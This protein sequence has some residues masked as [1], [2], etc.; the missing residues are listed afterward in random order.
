[1]LIKK[2]KSWKT[3]R[4]AALIVLAIL[5]MTVLGGIFSSPEAYSRTIQTLDTQK[6]IATTLSVA[7]TAASTTLSTLPEDT[8]SPIASELA[9][10]SL[11]LF[12][13]VC[14]L[15]LEKFLLTTF[16]WFAFT[17]LI[18]LACVLEI[19]YIIKSDAALRTYIR[20]I[21]ILALAL[22][23]IVPMSARVTEMVY[24]TFEDSVTS[25]FSKADGIVE[26]TMA[27][28]E[29]ERENAFVRFFVDLKDDV[30]SL[31]ETAKNMLGIFTD[32][33]AVL[34]ITSCV[35]P[36]LTA[37]LFVWVLKLVFSINVPVNNLVKIVTP[38]QRERLE[39]KNERAANQ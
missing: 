19:I 33:I 9:D 20:K 10:L 16:G 38:P 7:V 5:S 28:N 2:L 39:H 4:G 12:I 13:I 37:I 36:I 29:E 14:I 23:M 6:D 31:I 22:V 26:E 8:A 1:M 11:P 15:Y 27:E 24:E 32:A 30:V 25:V 3:I 17:L 34:L 21:L 35:I 18:P